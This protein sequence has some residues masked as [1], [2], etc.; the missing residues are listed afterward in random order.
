MSDFSPEAP[1][2]PEDAPLQSLIGAPSSIPTDYVPTGDSLPP[3]APL[4]AAAEDDPRAVLQ[5]YWGHPDF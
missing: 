3:D 1:V 4:N 5:R 2:Y